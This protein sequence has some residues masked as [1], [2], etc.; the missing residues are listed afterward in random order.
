MRLR[1]LTSE[2]KKTRLLGYANHAAYVLE[3]SMA[4]TPEKVYELLNQLWAPALSNA[5]IEEGDIR[6]LMQSE[7]VTGEVK[8]H[9][10]R[11]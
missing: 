2:T 3:Q 8:P 10:W 4:K 11:Y 1:N 5:R 7:G 9:D 6:K